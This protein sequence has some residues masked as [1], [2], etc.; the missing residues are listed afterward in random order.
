MPPL[1]T[2]R[3]PRLISHVLAPTILTTVLLALTPLRFPEVPWGQALLA[4]TFT[5]LI[6]WAALI[7][8]RGRG[9]V[10]DAHVTRR[11]QRWPLLL[12]ALAS[13]LAGLVLMFV[14]RAEPVMIRE[15]LL[16]LAGLLATGAVTLVWKISIHVAV[17]AFVFLHAFA[18]QP[19]G[20]YLAVAMVAVVSWARV[21]LSHHTSSQVFAGALV[22][23]L[24]GMLGL[25]PVL[26]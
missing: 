18:D 24:V 23:A 22:G 11:E 17:A 5:T 21:Q 13:I 1:T 2:S 6:P 16:I 12:V 20:P 7:W 8:A 15:V 19:Y 25:L 4:T 3:L 14:T 10:T 26:G 9:K